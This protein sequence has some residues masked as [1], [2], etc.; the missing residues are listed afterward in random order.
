MA[1]DD[2][3]VARTQSPSAALI[4]ECRA[5]I[6]AKYEQ[7]LEVV[8]SVL[9][10][11]E[12][13]KAQVMANAN[14]ILTDIAAALDNGLPHS[15]ESF[16]FL[17]WDIGLTRAATGVHPKESLLAAS[18]FFRAAFTILSK[19]IQ[20]DSEA[21][22]LLRNVVTTL[23]QSVS[24]RI[25]EAATSYAGFLLSKVH[26]AHVAERGRIAR[27]LHDRIGQSLSVAHRQA[28]L[29]VMY[30]TSDPAQA[31]VKMERVQ[32]AI[33]EAMWRLRQ[34][35]SDL[36][37]LEP[38]QSLEKALLAH[39]EAIG[40]EDM[41]AELVV[42]GDEVWA[43]PAISEECLLILSEAIRNALR[44]GRPS[45]IYIRVDIAPHELRASVI[46]DGCGFDVNRRPAHHSLGLA[47]IQERAALLGGMVTI[48][49]EVGRGTRIDLAVPLPGS[50][51]DQE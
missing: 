39:L 30:R 32:E 8:G 31:V 47:S 48:S 37:P 26:E 16:R 49:T 11:D 3:G 24:L 19:W 36:H 22:R 45:S 18:V 40:V 46:D 4:E 38:I 10:Q 33:Q 5:D 14:Q 41:T 35:T 7:D 43:T 50:F 27:E 12:Q 2:D 44:H 34:L 17:S 1:E 42:N 20:D 25:R 28:E 51:D 13:A 23:E 9:V 6:L 21:D 29:C 15:D